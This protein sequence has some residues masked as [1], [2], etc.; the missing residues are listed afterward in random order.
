MACNITLHLLA[1][2]CSYLHWMSPHP[3]VKLCIHWVNV[4]ASL[5]PSQLFTTWQATDKAEWEPGNEARLLHTCMCRPYCNLVPSWEGPAAKL[6]ITIESSY[7]FINISHIL[8]NMV[9]VLLIVLQNRKYVLVSAQLGIKAAAL[10]LVV[11]FLLE[12]CVCG[13]FSGE[14]CV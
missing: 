7:N 6:C 8:P 12:M 11:K 10:S 13:S 5:V 14:V 2:V 1:L 4:T 9:C 3:S